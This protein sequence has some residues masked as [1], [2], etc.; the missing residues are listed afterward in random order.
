MI[1]QIRTSSDLVATP[2]SYPSIT[3]CGE[4]VRHLSAEQ[5]IAVAR[6]VANSLIAHGLVSGDRIAIVSENRI[7]YLTTW[8]GAMMAGL[9]LTPINNRLPASK[10]MELIFRAKAQLVFCDLNCLSMLQD[11]P[12]KII[13]FDTDWKA[14]QEPADEHPLE[15]RPE[16]EAAL[17][18]F[19][20]GSSGAPKGVMISHRAV[21]EALQARRKAAPELSNHRF[22]V[23]APFYHMN[24]LYSAMFALMSGAGLILLPRF[25]AKD[26]VDAIERYR[27][28]WLTSVPTMMALVVQRLSEV[29]GVDVSSVQVVA[30]G[31][32]PVTSKLFTQVEK[33]FPDAA[34]TI[35][36][37]TTE[38]GAGIFGP[39]PDKIPRPNLSLGYPLPSVETRLY[40][41]PE[42]GPGK[43]ILHVRLNA[44]ASKYL[45]ADGTV[46]PVG[47]A[48]G[49]Y[50]TEDIML[51]DA[52]GFFSF[53]GR[54]DGMFTCGGENVFPEAVEQLIEQHPGVS[55]AIVIPVAD[56]I[57]GHKPIAFVVPTPGISPDADAIIQFTLKNGSAHQ[58][59]RKIIFLSE[60][61]RT[62]VEKIDRR[63]LLEHMKEKT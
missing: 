47:E 50:N 38:I 62:G 2:G 22:L 8:L 46:G 24:G 61:P 56:A 51:R 39:H 14:F 35:G 33:S 7:E 55:Q 53:V 49:W 17:M 23:A 21:H 3:D 42:T 29:P 31:S 11:A 27:A 43:G 41:A 37:G 10:V 9:C 20:S 32:S 15:S 48:D 34:L 57:K 28:T 18:L 26:Y 13:C 52:N 25:S 6:R 58:H 63:A 45:Y 44:M 40:G 60:L 54:D 19:T 5:I 12:Q 30:M 36:Y 16:E 1:M 4:R 59:P